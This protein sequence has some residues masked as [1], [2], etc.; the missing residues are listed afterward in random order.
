MWRPPFVGT[1][2][3]ECCLCGAV[4][5]DVRR[6][7]RPLGRALVEW[8]RDS[9]AN[10]ARMAVLKRRKPAAR[11]KARAWTLWDFGPTSCFCP[12]CSWGSCRSMRARLVWQLD[13]PAQPSWSLAPGFCGKACVPRPRL[14]PARWPA[15]QLS[16]AR[17]LP[18]CSADQVS[19]LRLTPMR[20]V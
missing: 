6:V 19:R 10:T 3:A 2:F 14:T 17:L 9:A 1:R 8:L 20:V 16:R 4:S 5:F 11:L 13:W 7:Q 15:N 12:L 18:P